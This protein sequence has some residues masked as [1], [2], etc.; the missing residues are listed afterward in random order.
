MT[1]IIG[2]TGGI[3]SGKT[4]LMQHAEQ[5]GYRTY[6]SD[7]EAKKL[8]DKPNIISELK[9]AFKGDDIWTTGDLDKKKLAQ[10]VFSD[11]EKLAQLNQ[12]IHPA[13]RQDF[14]DFVNNYH[15]ELIILKESAL[16]FETGAYQSCDY[17]ILITAPEDVRIQRVID[18][19]RVSREQVIAR[20]K[21][22]WS[23]HKKEKLADFVIQNIVLEEAQQAFL[24]ILKQ[25]SR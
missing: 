3:G 19:D 25:I 10:I 16:L 23:D 7:I 13:I 18:R 21:N 9:E 8:Y 15:N 2:V 1:K 5:Q 11:Q 6:Y 4:S 22:Q 24:N 20:M 14:D 17:N 12:I